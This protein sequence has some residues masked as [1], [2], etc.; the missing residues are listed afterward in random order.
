M[1]GMGRGK[2]RMCSKGVHHVIGLAL[3]ERGDGA[4]QWGWV[5]VPWRRSI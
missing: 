4:A 1:D 2:L 3:K 5:A